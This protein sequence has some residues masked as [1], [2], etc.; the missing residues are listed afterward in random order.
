MNK[1]AFIGAMLL[2]VCLITGLKTA[3]AGS[4]SA[5]LGAASLGDTM[6]NFADCENQTIGFREGL[7]ADRIEAKLAQSPALTAQERDIWAAEAQALRRSYQTHTA[8]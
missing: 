5:G 8:F 1:T 3:H 4:L 2:A 6:Q 7:I